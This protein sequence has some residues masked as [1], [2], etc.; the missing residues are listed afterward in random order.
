[1][2][3]KAP[4][5][6]QQ[7]HHEVVA[8]HGRDGDGL[9]DHHAGGRRQPADEGHE[10]QR[11]LPRGQRQAQHEGVGVD[12]APGE[13]QQAA[14]RD[15]QHEEVDGQQVGREHPGGAA[16]VA[17]LHV[18][19]H[20]HLELPRQEDHRQHRQQRQREPLRVGE[21]LALFQPQQRRQLGHGQRPGEQVRRPAEQAPGDEHAH[22]H[23]GQQLDQRLERDGRDQAF[24]ALAAVEVA[25]AEHH[26]EAGQRQ[27]HAAA[28][29]RATRPHAA[30]QAPP[31]AWSAPR[32]RWRWPSAAARCTAR[33]RPP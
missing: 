15:R 3:R 25:R 1:M 30:R 27:R 12:L 31:A 26:R 5:A 8:D 11:R 21:G 16:Q 2:V 7:R 6:Q 33:C 29:R 23:E 22:G 18:L 9:D 28:C 24:V 4:P 17:F 20:H 14:Q 13:E 10:R 19:D 32:S